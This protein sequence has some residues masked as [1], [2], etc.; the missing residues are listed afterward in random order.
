MAVASGLVLVALGLVVPAG[1]AQANPCGE[2]VSEGG[3]AYAFDAA[4]FWDGL[5]LGGVYL[6][7]HGS[8]EKTFTVQRDPL[9]IE[10]YEHHQNRVFH[11]NST[12]LGLE[13]WTG[14]SADGLHHVLLAGSPS[15]VRAFVVDKYAGM[16]YGVEPNGETLAGV[17]C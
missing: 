1:F 4:E 2:P 8:Y 14:D 16:V 11:A 6:F 9:L 17:A 3:R 13:R 10:F 12:T 7:E 5:R 15:H